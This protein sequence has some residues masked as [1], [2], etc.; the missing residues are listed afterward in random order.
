MPLTPQ[1]IVSLTSRARSQKWAAKNRH[2]LMALRTR[3]LDAATK[4]YE[5]KK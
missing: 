3:S 1:S 5:E 4:R 2:E